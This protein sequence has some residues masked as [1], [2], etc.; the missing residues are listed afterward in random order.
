MIYTVQTIS[1]YCSQCE[2]P[3]V[4]DNR[5]AG[6]PRRHIKVIEYGPPCSPCLQVRSIQLNIFII[7][8]YTVDMQNW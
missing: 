7:Q 2:G 5:F 6:E 3:R 4:C 8:Y 1:M